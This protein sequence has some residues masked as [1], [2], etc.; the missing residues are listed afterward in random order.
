[1]SVINKETLTLIAIVRDSYPKAWEWVCHKA[2]WEHMCVGAIFKQWSS[3]I[4]A[5]MEEESNNA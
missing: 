1:M 3:S 4:K 2:S 5:L